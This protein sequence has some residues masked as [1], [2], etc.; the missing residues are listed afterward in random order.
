MSLQVVDDNFVS[1]KAAALT[2]SQYA[3]VTLAVKSGAEAASRLK[4]PHD[5]DL[6]LLD[7]DMGAMDG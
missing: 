6:V 2:L 5:F 1:R 3:E 7:L 4:P